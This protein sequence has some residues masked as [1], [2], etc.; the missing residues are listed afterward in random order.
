MEDSSQNVLT[1]LL[2]HIENIGNRLPHP[3]SLFVLLC[4]LVLLLSWICSLIELTAVHPVTQE[5]I[6]ATNLLNGAGLRKI[7]SNAVTNFTHFAPLGSVLVAMLGIGIAEKAGLLSAFL[8]LLVIK[9]PGRMITSVVV[10]A[11]VLS[12][13][14]ADSGYVVLIPIAGLVFQSAGKN[15]LAGMAAAF[16]GVSGGYSANLLIGP[17]DAIL[18]GISTEAANL[19]DKEYQVAATSN[20]YFIIVSTFVI[21][22]IGTWVTEK[23]VLPRL[24]KS[25]I[26]PSSITQAISPSSPTPSISMDTLEKKGLQYAGMATLICSMILLACV[27]P[28]NA[29]LRNP[30]TGS[31]ISSPFIS[32]IVTIIAIFSAIVGTA[33]GIGA[34]TIKSDKDVIAAMEESMAAMATYLVL[35]FFAAQF[36]SYFSWT[37]LGLIFAVKGS[38]LL[39]SLEISA[40]PL[41]IIF[42]LMA[43]MINIFVGSASAKWA[44]MAPVFIPMF[45][46][47]G[48]SPELTQAAYRVGDSST[49]IITPLMPYFALVVAFMQKYD[50]QVG[51]GTVIATML[52]YSIAFIIAWS[53]LLTCWIQVGLPLGPGAPMT[54]SVGF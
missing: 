51:I 22:L 37:N 29:L 9:T 19:V 46:L 40:A 18:S 34:G 35:M 14:A 48:I 47:I 52:P 28:E 38:A 50:K 10:F 12:S 23:L 30:E 1:R 6:Q 4:G 21:T 45:M 17:L 11:G 15:P 42:I 27:L 36:V 49:N 8:R 5:T 13:L 43:A 3:T 20:Y 25:P 16:A 7:I 31:I 2:D 26:E 39:S 41:M 44:I 54:Y 53:V 24:D 33:Y 32:G